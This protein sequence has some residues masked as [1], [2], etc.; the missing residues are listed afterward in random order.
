MDIYQRKDFDDCLEKI[1]RI[2][3]DGKPNKTQLS[4]LSQSQQTIIEK[5]D[6][7]EK[8]TILGTNVA[9]YGLSF[10]F[11]TYAVA[12]IFKNVLQGIDGLILASV[13]LWL[14]NRNN[15]KKFRDKKQVKFTFYFIM[16]MV[17]ALAY[18]SVK[19]IFTIP[20]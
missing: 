8:E 18:L 2:N 6:N 3:A 1:R 17:I 16:G 5:L 12:T 7:V 20:S 14:G 4:Q 10:A 13:M 15:R 11:A 9:I 19:Y